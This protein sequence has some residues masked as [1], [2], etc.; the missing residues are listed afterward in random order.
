MWFGLFT[1]Y[2]YVDPMSVCVWG[3]NRYEIKIRY[4][5][6]SFSICVLFVTSFD[7]VAGA[8]KRAIDIETYI[9]AD[10]SCFHL[11]LAGIAVAAKC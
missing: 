9:W 3:E 6:I 2:L 8:L 11:N 5:Q 4:V 10:V 1:V 7:P